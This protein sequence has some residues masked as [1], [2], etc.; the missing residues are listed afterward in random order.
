[1]NNEQSR[2]EQMKKVM[3]ILAVSEDEL[4]EC[5]DPKSIRSTC[6]KLV[7]LIFK[8]KLVDA[9]VHFGHLLKNKD[10]KDIFAAI[11]SS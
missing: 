9:G 6:R 5:T 1:M 3:E 7:R 8:D 2:E 10:Y 4:D 11:R